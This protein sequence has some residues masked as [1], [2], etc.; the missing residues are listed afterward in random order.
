[1]PYSVSQILPT[2]PPNPQTV[3]MNFPHLAGLFSVLL[4]GLISCSPSSPDPTSEQTAPKSTS[5]KEPSD[6]SNKQSGSI[7]GLGWLRQ[8]TP[9]S[10]AANP[11]ARTPVFLQGQVQQQIPLLNQWLY[12]IQDDSGKI[13]ILTATP[14]P[15]SGSVVLVRSQIRYEQVLLQ[16]KD[17]GEYYAEELERLDVST[18]PPEDRNPEPG[19]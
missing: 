11:Q 6:S 17:I 8:V 3:T 18:D 13:W 15:N 4:I 2:I 12:E 16:G 10:Q 14:P 9:I 1:M 19:S 7:P 5:A